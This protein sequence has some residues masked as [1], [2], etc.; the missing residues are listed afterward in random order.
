V[1]ECA[2]SVGELRPFSVERGQPIL[3][4]RNLS[5]D[6]VNAGDGRPFQ[7]LEVAGGVFSWLASRRASESAV[8][9]TFSRIAAARKANRFVT[10]LRAQ[11]GFS[12]ATAR[13]RPCGLAPH[14]MAG[15]IGISIR[16]NTRKI[17]SGDC[18]ADAIGPHGGGGSHGEGPGEPSWLRYSNVT[19]SPGR[20]SQWADRMAARLA[21]R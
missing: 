20:I 13:A 9:P 14:I 21:A 17:H 19:F 3:Q 18:E 6:V 12:A 5:I 7:P 2:Q 16:A 8:L 10:T 11:A 1:F 4:N 15:Q